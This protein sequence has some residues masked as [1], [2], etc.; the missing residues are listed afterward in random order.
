MPVSDSPAF[1]RPPMPYGAVL[2]FP[3]T[4]SFLEDYPGPET[5]N[6]PAPERT[7]T[8]VQS[9]HAVDLAASRTD[10]PERWEMVIPKMARPPQR[11]RALEARVEP[12]RPL[13][14]ARDSPLPAA[15]SSVARTGS[16]ESAETTRPAETEAP[17]F[18]YPLTAASP[19]R[20]RAVWAAI[21]VS[22]AL[23][24]AGFRLFGAPPTSGSKPA[25]N[26]PAMALPR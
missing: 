19:R 15:P 1:P 5:L 23:L 25:A 10:G 18:C 9:E 4:W 13:E 6:R 7:V 22:A 2:S 12:A 26:E 17:S 3:V 16:S 20:H 24:A 11:T 14:P 8:H 21:F